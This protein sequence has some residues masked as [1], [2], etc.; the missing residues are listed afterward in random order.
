M[1]R[2]WAAQHPSRADVYLDSLNFQNPFLPGLCDEVAWA[3]FD[4][5]RS[6][7]LTHLRQIADKLR[8]HQYHTVIFPV[9][10]PRKDHYVAA[11]LDAR[12]RQ[13][14]I[15]DSLGG[16]PID[17][18]SPADLDGVRR[19]SSKLGGAM[20]PIVSE[21]PHSLQVDPF[22]CGIVTCNTLER[23]LFPNVR[24][25][26]DATKHLERAELALL[27]VTQTGSRYKLVRLTG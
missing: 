1:L 16:R 27:L 21:L 17:S 18:V 9:H 4:T 15:G 6:G 23:E 2:F 14:F 8:S 26:E 3:A 20:H 12:S 22:S 7:Q 5:D 19:F 24:P 13:L 11:R 25:W 10:D